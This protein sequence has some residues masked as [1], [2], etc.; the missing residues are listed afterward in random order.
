VADADNAYQMYQVWKDAVD[1][2]ADVEGLFPTFVLNLAP[3]TAARVALTNGI[4]NVWGTDDEKPYICR[5][6]HSLLSN[7]CISFGLIVF[8]QAGKLP[9]LGRMLWTTFVYRLGPKA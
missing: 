9:H 7:H 6:K 5:S 8:L 1:D 3:R 2:I 4:G